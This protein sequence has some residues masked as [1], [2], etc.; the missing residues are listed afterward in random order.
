MRN[1]FGEKSERYFCLTK[2]GFEACDRLSF[3]PRRFP[4]SSSWPL[5]QVVGVRKSR[6]GFGRYG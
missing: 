5:T 6:S 4:C 2:L 3:R 1:A